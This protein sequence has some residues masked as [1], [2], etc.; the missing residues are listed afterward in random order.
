[1]PQEVD[2]FLERGL[3]GEV[4]DIEA[5]IEQPALLSVDEADLRGGDDD[6]LETGLDEVHLEVAAASAMALVLSFR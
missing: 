1:M 2:R 4:I 3:G 6:V 5:A